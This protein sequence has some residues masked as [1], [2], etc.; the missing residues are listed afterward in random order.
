MYLTV[1]MFTI[2]FIRSKLFDA[3]RIVSG[4]VFLVMIIAFILPVIGT[5]KYLILSL[6]IA[7]I[8]S[9]EITSFKQYKGD[10][11]RLFLIHAFTVAMSLVLIILLFTV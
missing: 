8:S 7:I 6:A 10:D 4:I 11:K 5:D 1:S 3:L 2:L 9:I